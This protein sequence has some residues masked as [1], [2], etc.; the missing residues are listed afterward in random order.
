MLALCIATCHVDSSDSFF[1]CAPCTAVGVLGTELA[2]LYKGKSAASA[3]ARRFQV[4]NDMFLHGYVLARCC[5]NS[6]ITL[7]VSQQ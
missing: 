4:D 1:D 6:F 2:P 3:S 5:C 7:F